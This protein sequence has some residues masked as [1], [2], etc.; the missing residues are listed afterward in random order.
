MAKNP[1]TQR[2]LEH[3]SLRQSKRFA[4]GV[5][6]VLASITLSL[7]IS[8]LPP[9]KLSSP[10]TESAQNIPILSPTTS[11]PSLITRNQIGL[12]ILNASTHPGAASKVASTLKTQGYTI[13]SIGNHPGP[14]LPLTQIETNLPPE[15]LDRLLTDLGLPLSP[16]V[17]P[18][19]AATTTSATLLIGQNYL[20]D[21]SN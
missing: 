20:P 14:K 11:T 1:P 19:S 8:L 2:Q 6:V 13:S 10:Q 17:T 21:S 16:Q 12:T 5:G 15:L 3:R 9:P 7:A 4:L 18:G